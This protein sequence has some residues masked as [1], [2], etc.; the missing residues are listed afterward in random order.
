[1]PVRVRRRQPDQSISTLPRSNRSCTTSR[2]TMLVSGH[3]GTFG[4]HGRVL[5]DAGVA[6][7]YRAARPRSQHVA[8][9]ILATV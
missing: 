2:D 1:M 9:W 4:H 5:V 7:F 6:D 8:A 3:T